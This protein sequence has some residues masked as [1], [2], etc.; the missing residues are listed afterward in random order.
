M[1]YKAINKKQI[2]FQVIRNFT[3][4]LI[5]STE[6]F[7][8]WKYSSTRTKIELGTSISVT[9]VTAYLHMI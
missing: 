4:Y 2:S 5:I 3:L 8:N 1:S 9:V 6:V 7:G